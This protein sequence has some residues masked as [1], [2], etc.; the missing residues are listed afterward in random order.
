EAS[1]ASGQPVE[2]AGL[3]LDVAWWHGRFGLAGEASGRWGIDPTGVRAIVLGGSA[4]IRLLERMVASTLDPG[5][6]EFG[7]ELQAIVERAWWNAP[8]SGADPTAYGVGVA[9]RFRGVTD[10]GDLIAE[11][12]YFLRVMSS[13]W[14]DTG[15]IARTM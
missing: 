12:R 7:L 4:R 15:V 9:L 5:D 2:L 6:S 8:V 10:P 3:A 14:V 11:S 13:P 1:R